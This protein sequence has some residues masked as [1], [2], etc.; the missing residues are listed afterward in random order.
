MS[1]SLLINLNNWCAVKQVGEAVGYNPVD[2][3]DGSGLWTYLGSH[4]SPAW[5]LKD[6]RGHAAFKNPL[7]SIRAACRILQQYRVRRGLRTLNEI[8]H[9]WAPETDTVGSVPGGPNN[10]PNNYASIVALGVGHPQ[11]HDLNLFDTDG[12]CLD[13]PLLKNIIRVIIRMETDHIRRADEDLI[14]DGIDWFRRD[15]RG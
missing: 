11:D 3:W 13:K 14:L 6:L 9:V 1:E 10:D 7:Y 2:D 5:I 12:K 8:F 4:I 15:F